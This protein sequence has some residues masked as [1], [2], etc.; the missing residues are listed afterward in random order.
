MMLS[1]SVDKTD[2]LRIDGRSAMTLSTTRLP[3]DA[4]VVDVLPK[5]FVVVFFVVDDA[6]ASAVGADVRPY[7]NIVVG[8]RG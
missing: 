6:D 1:V 7:V 3:T 4:V 8:R 2:H 5:R